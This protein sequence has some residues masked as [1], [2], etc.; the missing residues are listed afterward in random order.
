MKI[1]RLFNHLFSLAIAGL[2]LLPL[3][4][5]LSASL[6]VPGLPPPRGIEWIPSPPAFSNYARIFEILPLGRYVFNSLYVSVIGVLLTL[7]TASWAGL[8]MSL[9]G[10]R[11]RLRLLILS[12][13]LQIIPI[14]AVWLTRFLL[15][16]WMG[17]TNSRLS[18][19][20]PALMGSSPL[21]ILLFYWTF[22]RVDR[23]LFETAELDGATLL[24]VWWHIALP[25]ARP[26]LM[27]VGMLSFL[28]YW[29]DF[30]SPLLYLR[31]QALFTLPLGL[32]QLQEMD[33]TNWPLLMAASVV[34]TL[35][36]VIVFSLL[37]RALLWWDQ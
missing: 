4:W 17:V 15:F 35:P 34:M 7:L 21:F 30:I 20:A 2:F 28:Y 36:A 27:A 5:M 25:L 18:L 31:S 33:K 23:A 26:A 9:L 10:K 24:Q 13:G 29:N 16:A 14:T 8:G 37:Q 19:L 32:L 22:R 6:R 1:S 11:A 12:A 3:F